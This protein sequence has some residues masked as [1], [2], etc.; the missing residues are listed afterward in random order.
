MQ[1]HTNPSVSVVVPAYN[2]GQYLSHTLD[3]VCEQTYQ[4][5]EIII[6]DDGSVDDTGEIAARYARKDGR[7]KVIRQRNGGVGA[8]RNAAIETARG[9]YIAPLDADD[10]W[11]PGKLERQVTLLEEGGNSWGLAYCW[12]KRIDPAGAI[13]GF[14]NEFTFR[15][16]IFYSLLF[17]NF[18][19]CAS[20]PLFRTAAV[21]EAGGYLTRG[22]QGGSQGCEDWLLLLKVAARYQVGEA[23]DF[24][25]G[26]R[27]SASSM[28]KN[29]VQMAESYETL[30]REVHALQRHIPKKLIRWSKGNFYFYLATNSYCYTRHGKPLWFAKK[31]VLADPALL[32]NRVVLRVIMVSLA[33]QVFGEN[34][35][36]S[37]RTGDNE[38]MVEERSQDMTFFGRILK[39]REEWIAEN[40]SRL[41]VSKHAP[42]FPERLENRPI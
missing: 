36:K 4:D 41:H 12:S 39:L 38:D 40:W 37:R 17:R 15:G 5:F 32:I 33:R 34:C 31:A 2:A 9:K 22:Q 11:F 30:L 18:I 23:Q 16:D 42:T 27:D 6:V 35:F 24:L 28:S 26:Y 19:G 20:V 29:V 21:R 7:I 3:S 1:G 8:A 14:S 10:I 25:V 13:M